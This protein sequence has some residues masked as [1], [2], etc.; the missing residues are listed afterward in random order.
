[1][2]NGGSSKLEKKTTLCVYKNKLVKFLDRYSK[3]D[4]KA[5]FYSY[6]FIVFN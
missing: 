2:C 6:L 3:F 1:M 4:L 5:M